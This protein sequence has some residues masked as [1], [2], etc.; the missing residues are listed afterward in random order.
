MNPAALMIWLVPVTLK[1]TLLAGLA[2]LAM[3]LLRRRS[4]AARRAVLAAF[5]VTMLLL[6][7]GQLLFPQWHLGLW[8][9]APAAPIPVDNVVERVGPEL[10]GQPVTPA[11]AGWVR[12]E[13]AAAQTA[14]GV[15]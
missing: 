14:N 9:P 12:Q 8:R 10:E 7:A 1:A 3:H 13:L 5:G 11:V 4:A 2:M 15:T 6:P